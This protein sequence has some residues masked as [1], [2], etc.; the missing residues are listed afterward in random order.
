[1]IVSQY[2][3]YVK[4]A[5]FDAL[6]PPILQFAIQSLFTELLSDNAKIFVFFQATQRIVI[7]SQIEEWEVK[8]HQKLHL[9]RIY[10]IVIQSELKSLIGA[11]VLSLR[12]SGTCQKTAGSVRFGFLI[13]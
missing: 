13:R 12:K 4:D 9:L 8:E 3:I 10:H 5:V 11:K 2:D 1:V 6:S 7:I